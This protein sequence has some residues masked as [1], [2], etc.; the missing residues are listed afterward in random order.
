MNEELSLNDRL[1]AEFEE[2][3]GLTDMEHTLFRGLVLHFP[4]SEGELEQGI[5]RELLEL[6]VRHHGGRVSKVLDRTVTHVLADQ[7]QDEIREV[8]RQRV[9]SGEAL[10]HL[11]ATAWQEESITSNRLAAV[12]D[13]RL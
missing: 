1:K 10:F 6:R 2:E 3:Y 5:T 8:R 12:E 11:L 9:R 4:V 7:V 13:Y